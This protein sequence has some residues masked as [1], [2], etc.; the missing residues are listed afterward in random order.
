MLPI[1]SSTLPPSHGS[2]P[3][4]ARGAGPSTSGL[5]VLWSRDEPERVGE[6]LLLPAADPGPWIFGRGEARDDEP[7]ISL[8]QPCPGKLVPGAALAC[9]RISRSQLRLTAGAGP[10]LVVDNIG[11][12]P[13]LLEGRESLHAELMPG[14]TLLLRNELLLMCIRRAPLAP[15]G[16]DAQPFPVHE[17]GHADA[18]GLVGEGELVWH[19]RQQILAVAQQRAHV[20]VLGESGC[21][22][23]LV[24]QAIHARSSRARLPMVSRNAAT[25]PE[26]LADAE[27]FGN[28]RG[29]P[30]PGMPERPGLIGQAH[31]ST[32]FLDEFAELPS[33]LQTHL[34]RVM[35]EGEYQRLGDATQ[36]RADL[37][38][39]AATNR[40]A[41]DLRHDALARFKI[42]VA[43]PDLNARKEDI[44]LIAVYLL[45]RHAKAD[46]A[47]AARFFRDGAHDGWPRLSPG[48]VEA[49]IRHQYSTHVR[50]L[51]ALLIRSELESRGRYLELT[52]NLKRDL[53]PP[54]PPSS[55]FDGLTAFTREEQARL[56]LLRR[57]RFSPTAC[58]RDAAYAGNRQT[59][60]LHLRHLACRA[61]QASGWDSERA[62]ALLAGQEDPE[63]ARK[64]AARI[65]KFLSNLRARLAAAG[66]AEL[67]RALAD[68][69][70][71]NAKAALL[72][73]DALHA[74]KVH[75]PPPLA[76]AELAH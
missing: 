18:F 53:E 55:P 75:E 6:V 16:S 23:E 42:R 19:L 2:D 1:D 45:R 74:G 54:P 11:S 15:L 29:Y 66:R 8:A 24:A 36:L 72:L 37:R 63:L 3:G 27:L 21:G 30:N 64:A 58:G 50:E 25:I 67:E 17:F 52:P 51:D 48:L 31:E 22:K 39:V 14:D 40:P 44:P 41:A 35:D 46:A 20:L 73:V 28:V 69:W 65:G 38:I 56:L 7:R 10:G 33:A 70:K 9:P 32:L 49:L 61:L 60:D 59:A 12:C 68:E 43:V 26:G 71:G 47:L 62:A 5:V 76:T 57:H 13:M 34:L 4:G